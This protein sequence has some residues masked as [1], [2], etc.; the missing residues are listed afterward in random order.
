MFIIECSWPELYWTRKSFKINQ[1][2]YFDFTFFPFKDRLNELGQQVTGF[3]EK[4]ELQRVQLSEARQEFLNSSLIKVERENDEL[5]QSVRIADNELRIMLH[6]EQ[7]R[8]K[9]I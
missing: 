2:S 3:A 9:Q 1:S 7:V 6:E 8:L 4:L 5:R